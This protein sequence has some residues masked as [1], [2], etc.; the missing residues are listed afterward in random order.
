[1]AYS[2]GILLG[3]IIKVVGFEGALAVKKEKVQTGDLKDM[4]SVF[5][6]IDGRPVPF[7][8]DELDFPGG[9]IIRIRFVGYA[10]PEKAGEFVGCRV[11]LPHGI[12]LKS[13]VDELDIL[14]GY[15]VF[16]AGMVKLGTLKKVIPNPG[17]W[18]LEVMSSS[19]KLI[20]IPFHEHFIAGIDKKK[21]H[22]IMDIPE[23]LTEL[24]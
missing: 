21:R 5:L 17:Q 6:E 4:E 10:S 14:V 2:T 19:G 3:R 23:G 20:L 8:I 1:M 9:D 15:I 11:F 22:L 12:A 18:L 24:N 13:P 7:F 16:T